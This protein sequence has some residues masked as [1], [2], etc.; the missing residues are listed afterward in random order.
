M[1]VAPLAKLFIVLS[2][3]S[4]ALYMPSLFMYY[5]LH[6]YTIVLTNGIVDAKFIAILNTAV[7]LPFLKLQ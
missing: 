6:N 1:M 2:I 5:E 3:F 7:D 4:V